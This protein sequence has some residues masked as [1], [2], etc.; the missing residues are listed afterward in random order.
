MLKLSVTTPSGGGPVVIQDQFPTEGPLVLEVP[1]N[2]TA[3]INLSFPQLG[4]IAPQ[5]QSLV[6]SGAITFT[7]T[8]ISGTQ[9]WIQESDLAGLPE[10]YSASESITIGGET[11]T[12]LYGYNLVAGQVCAHADLF[13]LGAA[14][15]TGVV[16]RSILP[17]QDGNAYTVTAV[18][19]TSGGLS[20]VLT[21]SDLVVD[22][23]G[24]SH[25]ATE[26]T[27]A[28]NGSVTASP[29]F[30]ATAGGNGSGNVALQ[31][32]TQL[33]GGTGSGLSVSCCGLAC[34]ITALDVS[35]S[36]VDKITITTPDLGTL[37]ANNGYAK[38]KVRSGEKK[39]DITV[40]T[41]S[42]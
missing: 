31:A 15:N 20:A 13:V 11:G 36:P 1:T 3:T 35:A 18:D 16:V 28:I 42:A 17:G 29:V 38:I 41:T 8:A 39:A 9:T 37:A 34:T 22:F 12:I 7:L 30:I 2:S 4:R 40:V 21:G 24:A 6:E 33:A 5:I 23:G 14:A 10:I 25:T 27:A 19:T 32:E 26:V